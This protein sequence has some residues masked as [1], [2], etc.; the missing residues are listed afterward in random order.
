MMEHEP[1]RKEE[2]KINFEKLV[3]SPEDHAE[4][5]DTHQVEED[6]GHH[7]DDHEHG[8]HHDYDDGENE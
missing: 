7:E 1:H 5:K 2:R 8:F 3:S 4:A 6:H